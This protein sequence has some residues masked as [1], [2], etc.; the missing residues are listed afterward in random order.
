MKQ[1]I[2]DLDSAVSTKVTF[3]IEKYDDEQSK[4]VVVNKSFDKLNR[5]LQDTTV[6]DEL[7]QLIVDAI[8]G[9]SVTDI[10]VTKQDSIN[11]TE[12]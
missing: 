6:L 11:K 1:S 2:M 5:E 9:R 8:D 3:K 4:N 12:Y 10:V 7:G